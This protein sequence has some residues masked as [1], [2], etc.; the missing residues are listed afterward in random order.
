MPDLPKRGSINEIFKVLRDSGQGIS[1]VMIR[2]HINKA[3]LKQGGDGKWVIQDVLEAILTHR[4]DDNK[5][6]SGAK[7]MRTALQCQLLKLE[8][9][10][11]KGDLISKQQAEDDLVQMALA[12]KTALLALP[13]KCATLV[14]NR[15]A[16]EVAEILRREVKDCLRGLSEGGDTGKD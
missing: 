15:G 5:T 14:E 10:R 12:V 16:V 9:D 7:E 6:A 11:Q 2:R 8:I 3:A 4:K 1:E 13:D